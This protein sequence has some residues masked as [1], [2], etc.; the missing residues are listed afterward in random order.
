MK[1][2]YCEQDLI[3]GELICPNCQRRVIDF[4]YLEKLNGSL[5]AISKNNSN[6]SHFA[7]ENLF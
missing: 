2:Q 4:D 5:N 7:F 3:E 1:C 6:G